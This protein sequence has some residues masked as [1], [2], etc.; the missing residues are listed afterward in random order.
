M[1]RQQR[2]EREM[3][4][5]RRWYRFFRLLTVLT[6]IGM[7]LGAGFIGGLFASVAKVLPSGEEL[8]D[9]NPAEPTRILASDGTL[10]AKIYSEKNHREVIPITRMKYMPTATLAIED[11]RF[12]NHPGGRPTGHR[13]RDG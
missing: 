7:A 9:I 3:V 5:R 8:A 2:K 1:T 10:L 12:Y 6:F 4:R 13:P 11:V